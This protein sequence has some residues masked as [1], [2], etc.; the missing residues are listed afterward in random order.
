MRQLGDKIGAKRLAEAA[1]VPVAPWSE[2]PVND[3]E[4]AVE[5]A[6]ELGLPV[7]IK[8]AAG[9][10]GRGIRRIDKLEQI[11]EA[12]FQARAEARGAFGDDTLFIEK[13]IGAARHIEVQ[14]I[15][16]LHG[17]VWPV[18]VRDCS[19]QRR[20]QKLLEEAPS[21]ALTVKQDAAIKQA[22]A[23]LGREAGY[24][25]AGTVEFLLDE[26]GSFSFMEVNTRLQVEHPVTEVTTGIDMVKLQ[27]HVAM[28]G[29]LEGD[30]PE[31]NGHAIEAR[32]NAED[33]ERG[34][35]PAPGRVELLRFPAG[36]GIRID[37]G[38]EEGDNIPSEF[39]SM[40]A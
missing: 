18:G 23:R 39:D 26:T 29:V 11:P 17:N 36:P 12:F 16:D 27:L 20:N 21:P 6:A 37:S 25:G 32:L 1:G 38:I 2:G 15:G 22:A 14:I 28:G 3:P 30:P 8:A 31:T 33:P 13:A 7:M 9:G 35:M 4:A 40:I 24:T 10:G 19:V 5:I 34:F